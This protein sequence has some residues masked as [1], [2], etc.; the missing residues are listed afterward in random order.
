MF[1]VA[2]TNVFATPY[3]NINLKQRWIHQ[4]GYEQ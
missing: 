4:A 1:L 2:Y 3:A